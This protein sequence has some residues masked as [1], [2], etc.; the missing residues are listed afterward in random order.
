[1]PLHDR[2][3]SIVTE[4][5]GPRARAMIAR[6]QNYVSPS[7][8]HYMP[9]MVERA[10]GCMIED[11]DGNVFLDVQAGIAT[12]STGHCHPRVVAAIR[13]QAD[14]LIHICGTDYHYPGYG[15]LCE[16]L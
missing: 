1:M 4:L 14:V 5:P 7:L 12:A 2:P 6:E 3:I 13:A 15:Q 9:L 8:I 10:S 11:V 16:T